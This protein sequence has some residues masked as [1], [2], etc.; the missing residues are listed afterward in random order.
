MILT[1]CILMWSTAC[2]MLAAWIWS[3]EEG[4]F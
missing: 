3:K 1:I 4:E 2:V